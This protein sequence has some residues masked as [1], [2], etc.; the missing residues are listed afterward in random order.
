MSGPRVLPSRL[1]LAFAPA[2]DS[3]SD[4]R[5]LIDLGAGPVERRLEANGDDLGWK[6]SGNARSGRVPVPGPDDQDPRS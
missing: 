5:I 2:P 3:G 4:R 1:P 6:P